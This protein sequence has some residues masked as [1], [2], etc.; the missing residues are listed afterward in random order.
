MVEADANL[1]SF[2]LGGGKERA[3]ERDGLAVGFCE[4]PLGEAMADIEFVG[5]V[6]IRILEI[7]GHGHSGVGNVKTETLFLPQTYP[8]K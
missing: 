3:T 4:S 7:D 8:T 2:D 6:D 1:V 5:W